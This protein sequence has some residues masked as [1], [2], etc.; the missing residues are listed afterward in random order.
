[1]FYACKESILLRV[2]DSSLTRHRSVILSVH[3]EAD[4]GQAGARVRAGA[5]A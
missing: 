1:M 2:N 4:A 3:C 5:V